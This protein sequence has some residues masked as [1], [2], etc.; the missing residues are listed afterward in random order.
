M[1]DL[2]RAVLLVLEHPNSPL[3]TPMPELIK[4]IKAE[5]ITAPSA[6]LPEPVTDA[7]QKLHDMILAERDKGNIVFRG[8]SGELM[9]APLDEFVKQDAESIL[10]DLN[11]LEEVS[12]TFLT[13]KK[14]V[15]DFAVATV[16]RK[17]KGNVQ[18]LIE[19]ITKAQ[20]DERVW[21]AEWESISN[22]AKQLKEQLAEAVQWKHDL[23]NQVNHGAAG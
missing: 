10:Y 18:F 3:A 4:R 7:Q 16:I 5:L 6:E 13:D 9:T 2:L 14:W 15:N 22:V 12:L 19:Q 23:T 8:L 21:R 1:S 20:N 17:L 11:R